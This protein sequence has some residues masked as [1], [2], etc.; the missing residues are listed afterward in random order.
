MKRFLGRSLSCLLL[1]ALLIG[2]VPAGAAS[3]GFTDVPANSWAA[4]DIRRCVELGLFQGETPTRFGMGRQMTRAAFTVVLCRLFGWPMETPERGTYADVQ[5]TGAWYYS[6]VETAYAH[7]AITRQTENF[8]PQDPIT[9]GEMAVMLVRALGWGTVAGLAQDLPMPFTD[10]ATNAGYISMAYELGIINGTSATTFSPDRTATREQAAVMLMRVYDKYHSAAPALAGT[11]AGTA[12]G[13]WSGYEAV[14]ITGGRVSYAAGRVQVTRPAPEREASLLAAARDSGAK[15]LL[16]VTG[17][18]SALQGK[19]L[20]TASALARAVEDG[21]YDGLYLD[22]PQLADSRRS[23]LTETVADL[24]SA[25]GGK[26]LY[27]TAE[28]PA[29]Q[30]K[31]YSAYDYAALAAS[32]DRLVLRVAAYQKES[33]GFT[34]APLEP[35]EEVYY[36]LAELKGTVPAEK[37]S[38]LLTT[39][40][41]QWKNGKRTFDADAGEIEALLA[42]GKNTEQYYANRYACAYLVRTEQKNT[43]TVWYLD[44]QASQARRQLAAF[45]GVDQIWLS[46]LGSVSDQMLAGL[47]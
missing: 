14:A 1:A 43:V 42:D 38:L 8:R 45:F 37:L 28:A 10:V 15:A 2:A 33:G 9:R 34:A 31:A 6:A 44:R 3:A 26:L 17:G 22:L 40:G 32:A 47:Q 30:G 21:G 4:D 18:S 36:A 41:S 16:H 46:D 27:V 24:R 20:E 29:W 25:L 11:A 39:T 5:D 23:A 19:P 35:M 12:A 7:G 13:D